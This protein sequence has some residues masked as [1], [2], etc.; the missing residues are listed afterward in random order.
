MKA[1]AILSPN[2]RAK[3][4]AKLSPMSP[5][6]RARRDAAETLSS[7]PKTTKKV[8]N[9]ASSGR[10]LTYGAVSGEDSAGK[11]KRH[12]TIE[13]DPLVREPPFKRARQA[14]KTKRPHNDDDDNDD[15]DDD[16]DVDVDV[17]V[18]HGNRVTKFTKAF[19]LHTVIKE[20]IF[21]RQKFVI[22][23][24]D[25]KFSNKP[26]SVCQR[27]ASKLGIDDDEI[28]DWWDCTRKPTHTFIKAHRNNTISGLRK[29]FQGKEQE[30]RLRSVSLLVN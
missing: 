14:T 22:L 24:S 5:N 28:E 23:D 1:V 2:T 17:D 13:I 6:T 20:H 27:M 7:P 15:D 9:P 21:T 3:V 16:D 11:T 25:L 19:R 18:D 10:T 26:E 12:A 8:A 29:L 30:Q 4:A